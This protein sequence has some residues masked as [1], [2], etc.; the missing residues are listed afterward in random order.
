MPRARGGRTIDY[1][2]WLAVP[3]LQTDVSGTS[4]TLSGALNFAAP[5]T[6]LRCRGFVQASMDETKQA[7]DIL[8]IVWALGIISTDA[9]TAGAGSVPD[10]GSE[11]EYPWL[12]WGG[13][14]L[15]AFV[16][17]GIEQWGST[18][19]RLEV[20]TKAMRRI[21]PGTSLVY[22]AQVTSATGAPVTSL[23]FGPTRVLIGT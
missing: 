1:K 10:P 14:H 20:D 19:Q 6:V 12:W 8:E 13:M 4:T 18:S 9:F 15:E 22:M 17:V 11:P 21:K 3:A 7:G 5:A 2:A 23:E 16:A